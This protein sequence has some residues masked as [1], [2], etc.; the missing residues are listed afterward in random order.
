MRAAIVLLEAGEV[1]LIERVR[2]GR[3]YYLFPGGSVESG[4]APET[5]AARDLA[6]DRDLD[7]ELLVCF[8]RGHFDG[9][10]QRFYLVRATGGRFGTGAGE[11]LSRETG[12]DVGSYRAVRWP[13]AGLPA[14]DVRPADLAGIVLR[15]PS[16]GW[17]AG[18]TRLRG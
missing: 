14:I 6:D 16:A 13:L 7:A 17:P 11:E 12:A 9:N 15:S 2:D 8:A 4:E 3:H 10:E 5:A 18:V 1:A